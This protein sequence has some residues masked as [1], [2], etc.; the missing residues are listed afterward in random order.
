MSRFASVRPTKSRA[1]TTQTALSLAQF[2]AISRAVLSLV[3]LSHLD[4]WMDDFI[5]PDLQL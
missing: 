1:K 4:G 2:D 3:V 5:Y